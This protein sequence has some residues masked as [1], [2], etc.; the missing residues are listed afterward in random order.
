V[1]ALWG[2]AL[3]V[4]CAIAIA[5]GGSQPKSA[6][7][8]PAEMPPPT[9]TGGVPESSHSEI[10]RLDKEIATQLEQM[11]LAPPAVAPMADPQAM[12]ADTAAAAANAKTCTH[13]QSETC[14]SACELSD[15]ICTNAGKI[16]NLASQLSNDQWANQ[17]CANGK[18]SCDAASGRC[19]SCQP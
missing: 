19:C 18:A 14:K 8:A 11:K 6:M 13:G 15:S 16:C 4:A 17:K 2:L 1:K 9:A 10:D 12:S 5:C 3:G 7:R